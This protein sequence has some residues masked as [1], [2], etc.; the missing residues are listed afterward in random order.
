MAK[1]KPGNTF[2]DGV[3]VSKKEM[4]DLRQSW[5]LMMAVLLLRSNMDTIITEVELK[6]AQYMTVIRQ[7]LIEGS[8]DLHF[9]GEFRPVNPPPKPAEAIL[10]EEVKN[11]GG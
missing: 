1:Q 4:A 8:G 2:T 11:A 5:V 7:P 3:W 6:K 10:P 9:T